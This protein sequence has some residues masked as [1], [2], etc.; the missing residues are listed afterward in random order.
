MPRI[1]QSEATKRALA[2]GYR[3]GLEDA[4]ADSLRARGCTDFS[5]EQYVI[6]YSVPARPARYTPDIVLPN[7]I[8]VETKGRWTPD[9][10]KKMALIRDQFPLLDIRMVFSRSKQRINKTSK[11]TYADICVKLGLP[12]ADKDIPSDWLREPPNEAAL[13][14]L[15]EMRK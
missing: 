2:N 5:Y 11:T 3:S 4:V 10:R 12:Y 7:G 8:I 15:R 6:R 1:A 13:A 9:D 14:A